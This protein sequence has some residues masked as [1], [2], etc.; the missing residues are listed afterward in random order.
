MNYPHT[1]HTADPYAFP[2]LPDASAISGEE[3]MMWA[4]VAER[5][6]PELGM[7]NISFDDL[8]DTTLAWGQSGTSPAVSFQN[9]CDTNWTSGGSV[10]GVMPSHG[11]PHPNATAM[12]TSTL[13]ALTTT[14]P[15]LT[16]NTDALTQGF[17]ITQPVSMLQLLVVLS[18]YSPC[19]AAGLFHLLLRHP[20]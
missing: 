12:G 4:Q 19:Y 11:V 8:L 16:D 1:T 14:P 10:V 9:D 7:E 6:Q 3:L 20:M 17:F 5:A 13:A 2:N 18:Y 15:F